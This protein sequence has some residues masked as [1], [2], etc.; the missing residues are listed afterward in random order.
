[1]RIAH[2]TDLHLRHHVPGHAT[3]T[4]RRSRQAPDLLVRALADARRR[5][6]DAVMITGDLVD[7]PSYLFDRERPDQVGDDRLWHTVREDYRLVRRLLDESGLPWISVPGRRDSHRLHTEELGSA[8]FV[9][10]LGELR[11]VCFPDRVS[12]GAVPRRILTERLRFDSAM[13][14]PGPRPQVH[15]QP[16]LIDAEIGEGRPDVYQEADFLR[17]RIVDSGRVALTLSGGDN[18]GQEPTTHG[19]TT[20]GVGSALTTRPHPYRI[21]DVTVGDGDWTVRAERIELAPD[22]DRHKT[23]FLD[24]D[25]CITLHPTFHE[26]PGALQLLPGAAPALRLLREAG[27]TLV[28]VTNQACVGYG[29]VDETTMHE[30]HDRMAALLADEGA[31]VDAVYASLSAGERSVSP[32]FNLGDEPKPSPQMLRRAAEELHLDL[33][34]SYMIGDRVTDVEVARAAGATPILVRTGDGAAV[35]RDHAPDC[36]VADDLAAAAGLITAGVRGR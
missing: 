15:L 22:A 33:P 13:I 4:V 11:F 27:F 16:F 7:V 8:P 1:M 5:D 20:F 9:R 35:E 36:L 6:V 3:P 30:V 14:D 24:R 2:L 23:V 31:E 17:Q 29:F 12:D 21:F 19:R 18:S 32:I 10:D 26:G 34:T 25:G 28:V